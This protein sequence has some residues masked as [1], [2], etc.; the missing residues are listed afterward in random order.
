MHLKREKLLFPSMGVI[1]AF[2]VVTAVFSALSKSFFTLSTWA[3]ILTITGE[4]GTVTLPVALLMISGEFD[5]SVGSVYATAGILLAMLLNHGFNPFLA[6]LVVLVL[7][8]AIGL[9][10]GLITTKIR[11]PSF[12]TTLGTM[13][14]IRGLLLLATAGFP[15]SYYGHSFLTTFLNGK[16]I[17]EF[18]VSAIWVIVFL[19]LFAYLLNMTRHGNWTFAVG[20]N[21]VVAHALG[22]Q[23]DRVKIINFVLSASFASVAGM[24]SFARFKMAYPT[25]GEQMGLEAIA[26]AVLG[27][28]YLNGGYGT[29]V[30][31][32]FGAMVIASLRVGLVLAGAPSYWYKAFIG[33]IL[34]LGMI[35]NKEVMQRVLRAGG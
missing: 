33:I 26:A 12:I 30:G 27:G 2:I 15:V 6:L 9:T 14:S 25:L 1:V 11:I 18:R 32:F 10:N 7:G 24:L 23:V 31:A 34:V 21:P 20:G 13:M 28:C 8:A 29:I 35:I 3:G 19:G 22:V 5:L 4:L 16:I 17:G